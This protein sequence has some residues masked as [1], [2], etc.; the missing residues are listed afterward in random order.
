MQKIK[1]FYES[2]GSAPAEG[3]Y[4]VTLDGRPVRTPAKAP[5]V[6]PSAALAAAIAE[7]W[8]G[9][10]KDI[11]T[12]SMALNNLACTAIDIVGPQRP[13]IVDDLVDYGGHDLICYWSDAVDDLLRRQQDHW[14]PLLD[15]AAEALNA[16]LVKTCGIV[17]QDQPP[18]SLAALR[19]AVEQHDAMA[20]TGLAAAVQ[21]S[22]SLVIGLALSH[23]RMEAEEAW[24]VSLL[25]EAYQQERWGE[26]AEARKRQAALHQELDAAGRFLS[27]LR[28]GVSAESA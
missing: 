17:S 6:L 25:D 24:T 5:L 9:Q 21:A 4:G 27:L 1:R 7:E 10:D 13:R 8:Q 3:G 20:L 2:A 11:D 12:G 23:G 18:E 14:Q 26:D 15:W 22:G 16:P 19:A 28:E